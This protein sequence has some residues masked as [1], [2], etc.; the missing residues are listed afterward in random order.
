MAMCLVLW[1]LGDPARISPRLLPVFEAPGRSPGSRKGLERA[2]SPD[3][4]GYNYS[5][6]RALRGM[7]KRTFAPKGAMHEYTAR[8][9]PAAGL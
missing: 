8:G 6:H 5:L 2:L 7:Q 4:N 9:G 3:R 1:H